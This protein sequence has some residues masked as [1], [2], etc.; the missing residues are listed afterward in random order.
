MK[1]AGLTGGSGTGKTTIAHYFVRQYQAY[2]IDADRIGHDII[3]KGRPAYTLLVDHFGCE[4]LEATE[5]INRKK[6]GAIVFS[7]KEKLSLLNEITHP[8]IVKEIKK[9]IHYAT[10]SQE[11][12]FI[13]ID[14]A[15]LVEAKIHENV[16]ELWAVY[17]SM[18]N[19]ICRL[20]KRDFLSEAQ[21]KQRIESQ[22]PW[23][24]LKQ[25]ANRIIDNNGDF[26]VTMLQ[27]D[28]IADTFLTT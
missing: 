27:C 25:Y 11:Y 7:D 6:L 2:L 9:R 8:F 4:I 26:T 22:M 1:V 19:R 23:D 17:T 10:Q 20:K 3:K 18:E 16:D 21:I 15:L 24:T 28:Q 14:G 12:S 13:L 5:G